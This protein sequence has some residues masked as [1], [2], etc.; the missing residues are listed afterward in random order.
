[1][2]ISFLKPQLATKLG[3]ATI[4]ITY[5]ADQLSKWWVLQTFLGAKPVGFWDFLS[6][7]GVQLPFSQ[8]PI[9]G[10]FNIVMVWNH[11]I[12]FGLLQHHSAWAR[13]GLTAVSLAISLGFLVWLWQ[14]KSK[15]L[16][17]ALGLVVG[18]AWGNVHDRVRFGAVVDFLDVYV[19]NCH[20]PS[21]NV[22][23]SAVCLGVALVMC[24]SW[25]TEKNLKQ[26]GAV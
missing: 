10:F 23:D 14:A 16:G 11:G 19:G 9:T 22:A 26:K 25:H 21:F 3:L 24:Y 15:L 6:Q 8:T 12:S 7:S 17:V 20:W 13:H 5:V 1:M 18:G 4:I 2:N